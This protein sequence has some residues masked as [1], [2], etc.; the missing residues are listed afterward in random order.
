MEACPGS[1]F[2]AGELANLGHEVRLIVP[3]HVK[4]Y[5]LAQK[6]DFNDA[7]AIAEA[8]TWPTRFIRSYRRTR[9]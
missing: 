3:T 8:V 5:L 1:Q 7:R 2:L 6:N 9:L 4:R